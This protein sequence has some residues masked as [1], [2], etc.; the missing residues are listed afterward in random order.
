[1]MTPEWAAVVPLLVLTG[2]GALLPLIGAFRVRPGLLAFLTTV[3]ILVAGVLLV[4]T[5]WPIP[6]ISANASP[7]GFM[8]HVAG[9]VAPLLSFQLLELTPF[10]VLFDLV[11]LA[12]ALIVTLASPRY[13]KR[14]H[15]G[16]YY[17][18]LL[19]S[20]V[21]MMVVAGSR[22]LITLFVGLEL[23]SFCTYALA[24]FHKKQIASSEA[25]MKYFL[26][27]SISSALALFGISLVYGLTGD[28][29]FAALA[30]LWCSS[31]GSTAACTGAGGPI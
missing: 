23:S 5:F 7:A 16:E 1:M 15:Q 8:P 18:L 9:N 3:G 6:A 13:L 22:E 30:H 19:L 17:S 31:A 20:T 12:V 4:G 27:G 10:V 28:T 21:G 14:R 2:F 24:G 29:S 26:V 25:S 11:F